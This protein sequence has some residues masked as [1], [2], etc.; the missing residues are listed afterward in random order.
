[1][2]LILTDHYNFFD[3]FAEAMGSGWTGGVDTSG[4]S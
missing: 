2:K 1:M 4:V 3:M